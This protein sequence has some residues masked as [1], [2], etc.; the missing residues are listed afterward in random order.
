MSIICR[1][2]LSGLRCG[3]YSELLR[4]RGRRE[5]VSLYQSDSSIQNLFRCPTK[6]QYLKKNQAEEV[7]DSV[8]R[9]YRRRISNQISLIVGKGGTACQRRSRGTSPTI[10][11]VAACNKSATSDPTNVIPTNTLRSSSTTA[12]A[13][14]VY[15]SACKN[16]PTTLSRFHSTALT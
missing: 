16:A 7:I 1:S 11:I 13:L 9:P 3:I 8:Y 4:N 6:L 14:P 5:L 10:A 2:Q 15:P 12:F